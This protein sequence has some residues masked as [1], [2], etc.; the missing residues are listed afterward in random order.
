MSKPE[1]LR[2]WTLSAM[3]S[4]PQVQVVVIGSGILS[5][6]SGAGLQIAWL[7]ALL[8]GMVVLRRGMGAGRG[9]DGGGGGSSG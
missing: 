2:R 6:S 4:D 9:R 5:L 8:A 1:A 3:V 7:V